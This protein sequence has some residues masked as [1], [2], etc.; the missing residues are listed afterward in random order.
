MLFLPSNTTSLYQPLDQGIIHNS[1]QYY[2]QYFL[3]WICLECDESVDPVKQI[4][5]RRSVQWVYRA[6]FEAVKDSNINRCWTK[7][8]LLILVVEGISAPST[9]E[10]VGVSTSFYSFFHTASRIVPGLNDIEEFLNPADENLDPDEPQTA[11]ECLDVVLAEYNNKRDDYR[12]LEEHLIELEQPSQKV[13]NVSERIQCVK[14]LLDL[15]SENSSFDN[16]DLINLKRLL[17]KLQT[18][19]DNRRKQTTLDAYFMTDSNP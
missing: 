14:Q 8:T 18:N 4:D 2:R 1:K 17:N 3:E 12:N 13:I 15:G 5:L 16:S 9:S 7:S 19:L 10:E 11:D 6:W